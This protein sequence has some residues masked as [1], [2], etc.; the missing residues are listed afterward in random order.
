M[1]SNSEHAE[2]Q[3]QNGGLV[4]SYPL[5]I[6]RNSEGRIRMKILTSKTIAFLS[7]PFTVP[8][9]DETLPAGDYEIET[10]LSSPPNHLD[11]KAWK[12]S[13]LVHQRWFRDVTEIERAE[14]EGMPTPAGFA[15]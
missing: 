8:G 4:R 15:P 1:E 5:S 7:R 2:F 11:P 6:G 3:I 14:N 9:F 10:E 12:T 13:V